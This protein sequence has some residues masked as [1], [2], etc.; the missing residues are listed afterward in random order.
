MSEDVEKKVHPLKVLLGGVALSVVMLLLSVLLGIIAVNHLG[1]FDT[2]LKWREGNYLP[3][4]LWRLAL[5]GSIVFAWLKLKARLPGTG[6]GQPSKGAQ[7]VEFLVL[8][9]F[10]IIEISKAPI[11]WSEVL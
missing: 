2:W 5:Y 8:L 10:V 4:L 6:D 9:L 11:T 3:L 1:V 7:R